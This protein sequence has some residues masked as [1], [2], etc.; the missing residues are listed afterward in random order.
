MLKIEVNPIVLFKLEKSFPKPGSAAK[1][2]EKYR[3]VFEIELNK[4]VMHGRSNYETMFD[5]YSLN[6]RQL[7][8]KGPQIG[9]NKR[10][11]HAWLAENGLSFYDVA[12]LG[13]NLTGLLSQVKL[14]S[15]I[16]VTH[17]SV[18]IGNQIRDARTEE[19]IDRFLIGDEDRHREVFANLYPDYYIFQSDEQ[20]SVVFDFVPIEVDSLKAYIVWLN[21]TASKLK[22][23]T[24]AE[25]TKA[26]IEILSVALYTNGYFLQRKKPSKFGRMYYVGLSAQSVSKDLRSA[27]LG[28]CWELDLR[29]SVIA[30]KLGFAEMCAQIKHPGIEARYLF[31]AS[32][33]YVTDRK[34]FVANL[35]GSVFG[36][37]CDLSYDMQC[38]FVKEALTAISFGARANVVGWKLKDGSWKNP[39]LKDILKNQEW[40][41]NF[42][43]T[44]EIK[45]FIFE[46]QMLDEFF[47]E[48]VALTE[49][50]ILKKPFLFSG[51]RCSR[52]KLVAYI[53]Q[54]QETEMMNFVREE[55]NRMCN[56]VLASIHDAVVVKH[57]L[58]NGRLAD[59]NFLL[60]EKFGNELLLL[61]QKKIEG[62][63]RTNIASNTE[64]DEDDIS[65]T[66]QEMLQRL[67]FS[68]ADV[69]DSWTVNSL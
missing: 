50:S 12:S 48:Q 27:M 68:N 38:E 25:R 58:I 45:D 40:H 8:Q 56:P 43:N 2:L 26:A 13:N 66:V 11:L 67:N 35:I 60:R 57:K 24:I 31:S 47:Y 46:Q 7:S 65:I 14:N 5:L 33:W 54:S 19:E 42:I 49:P 53:Y 34:S 28:N 15:M 16:T 55:L 9:P 29:S 23:N 4:S 36:K 61:R 17:G 62:Y 51:N 10:R 63:Q 18:S 39:A 20:R 41:K 22:A 69:S 64:R 30:F 59:I 52:S 21:R 37:E 1:A 44:I 3:L 32:R 6:L